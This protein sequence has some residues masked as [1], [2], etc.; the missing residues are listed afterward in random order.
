VYKSERGEEREVTVV[1]LLDEHEYSKHV[2]DLDKR[3]R[4]YTQAPAMTPYVRAAAHYPSYL[5]N[6][7]EEHLYVMPTRRLRRRVKEMIAVAVS[8]VNG[9][10][11]CITAHTRVLKTMF[12]MPDP[13]IVELAA[14]V[15]HVSGV[16]R[17]ET[18]TMAP[19]HEPLFPPR[20]PDEVPLL[21]DI[22]EAL[23]RIPL[24]Y[25]IMANDPGFL[26][27]VWA[28]E[29]VTLLSGELEQK[30]KAFV[31]FATSI[32]NDAPSAIRL[33]KEILQ[34]QLGATEEDVFEALEVVEIFHKN[35]KFTEGLQL[36]SGLWGQ[37]TERQPEAH[38]D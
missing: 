37:K 11:Y 8:M 27:S 15:A 18:A 33:H 30:D 34:D 23:G 19:G 9:C 12:K 17:F 10:P 36:E 4:Q 29:Q 25:Q 16:N 31:A 6:M 7:A 21:K 14:A 38:E 20:S 2:Q 24:V 13:E 22:E 1:E 28:R 5:A 26:E 3:V 35:T 32:A